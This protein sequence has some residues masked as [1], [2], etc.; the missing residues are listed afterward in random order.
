MKT[1]TP[2]LRFACA[3]IWTVAVMAAAPTPATPQDC[4][5]K[6][7]TDASPD[8]TD[9]ASMIHSITS[10][11]DSPAEKC[12]AMFY[13]NHV[14]RRQTA[15]MI[16]HG[17]EL[18]D[19]IRQFND[20]GYTMCSTISGINCGIWHNMG[21]KPRFWDISNHTVSEVFYDGRWH[22][23]D[24]SM[25]A[26]YTLCDGF[27]LAGVEDVGK[28]AACEVSGGREEPGH[29][30]RYHCLTAT[31]PN[32]FLTG[33]DCARS[34]EEEYRCFNPNGLKHRYYYFN[35]DWGHRYVLNLRPNETYTR[36]Y[37]S[38]GGDPLYFVPNNG[39]DPES[40]N[41]RYR[42][43][44][45]GIWK[46]SPDLGEDFTRSLHA[47][48]NLAAAEPRGIRPARAGQPAEAVFRIQ[49]A[50]VTTGQIIRA[51]FFRKSDDDVISLAVSATNGL[52]WQEIWRAEG[53]GEQKAEVKLVPE[54]NGAYEILIKAALFA[55]DD[56]SDAR[57]SDIG[58]ETVTMVNSKTLPRLNLG[59][60]TVYVGMGD[61]LD[62]IVFWPELQ[63]GR[64]KDLA[65][66]DKNVTSAAKHPG[67]QAV[68]H[69]ARAREDAYVVYRIDAPRDVVRLTWG[70]R[71]YNRAP[72]SRVELQYSVNGAEW[73]SVWSITRTE[74]PWD[75]IHYET[76]DIPAGHR[77][78]WVR[79]LMNTTD[80]SPGGCGLYSVRIEACHLPADPSFRPLEVTFAWRERGKDGLGPVRSHTQLVDR[81]PFRY[82]INVGGDDHPV[83]DSLTVNVRGARGAVGAGYSD[84]A[85]PGGAK[86][87]GRRIQTGVNLAVGRPYTVS[88]PSLTNW[89]A[90]DPGGRK[91]TDGI[92][93]P[94]YA[95]G[96]SYRYGALWSEAADPVEITVD[97]G[98]TV[99]AAAFGMNFHGYPFWDALKR[100]IKDRVEVLTSSDG[101]E[102]SPAGFLQTDVLWKDV[103]VNHM[104]TDEETMAG[105]AFRLVPDKPVEARFV[106]YRVFNKRLF[107]CTELEVL[108]SIRFE[109][110]D[111]R[112]ALP[113][114]R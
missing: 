77:S 85:D 14:A 15:P 84:G 20:Y 113:D 19:P 111:M 80:P 110:F 97:L 44:G 91:L 3:V 69:P 23:Y 71:F 38:L 78:V 22:V 88:R 83:M 86:H 98:R 109:P 48:E 47:F 102:F 34:L 12:W 87:V 56:P 25:S 66:E 30:A 114:E 62:S 74:P 105:H 16:L 104:W 58:I 31:S 26:I 7:V 5:V 18:T 103:P 11:W 90:G 95:G 76:V 112:I 4:N 9:M 68:L 92:A 106:R 10:K 67:Y 54:V 13:W 73:R 1:G 81:V 89:G 99:S 17:L 75:E 24:N 72:R 101:K 32:G 93:G 94:P 35:W 36:Y 61:Q 49:S 42:I 51:S 27:T 43:R 50:N 33:A 52:R 63:G 37:R 57:L 70:G 45:N 29:I 108:D 53:K 64:Y 82:T 41:P 60:N 46:Y 39:K 107:C 6:V 79:Y 40:V 8:Y 65:V 59:R 96:I 21:L 100:E 2:M 28:P 55:K